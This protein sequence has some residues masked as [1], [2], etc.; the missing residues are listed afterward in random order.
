MTYSYIDQIK[1][2]KYSKPFNVS[3]FDTIKDF[4][5]DDEIARE[6]SVLEGLYD[7]AEVQNE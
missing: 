5:S 2:G 1:D 6:Y 3:Q 4:Y 7:L